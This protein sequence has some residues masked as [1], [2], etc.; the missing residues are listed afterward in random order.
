M[1]RTLDPKGGSFQFWSLSALLQGHYV[2]VLIKEV[3]QFIRLRARV[4]KPENWHEEKDSPAQ[5]QWQP[6][7][8]ASPGKDQ[9]IQ[10]AEGRLHA[11][12]VRAGRKTS[13]E[14]HLFY[15]LPPKSWN[16][17]IHMLEINSTQIQLNSIFIMLK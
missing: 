2:N 14:K 5:D 12:T 10:F 11:V 6:R 15:A 8:R 17:L 7:V 4:L 16:R 1:T 3:K 13:L 9:M